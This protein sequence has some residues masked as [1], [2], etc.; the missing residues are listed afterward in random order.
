MSDKTES[1]AL[2]SPERLAEIRA[3]EQAATRGP[4]LAYGV[5]YNGYEDPEIANEDA[6]IA[7]TVYDS[8]SG[9]TN[10]NVD[11]DTLFIAHTRQDIPAL[12]ADR[13]VFRQ[14]VAAELRLLLY[15]ESIFPQIPPADRVSC[16]LRNNQVKNAAKAL[17]IDLSAA[18]TP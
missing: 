7:Q 1:P 8:Q 6:Y 16:M 17:K 14:M 5:P 9:S 18:P 3:R 12:L 4:W 11:A 10:H 13:D 2:L 15:D